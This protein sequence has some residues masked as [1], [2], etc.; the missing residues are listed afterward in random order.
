MKNRFYI[1]EN[2]KPYIENVSWPAGGG[3]LNIC[4][5]NADA[6][7]AF[8]EIGKRDAIAEY[9]LGKGFRNTIYE[10]D[11]EEWIKGNTKIVFESCIDNVW[12]YVHTEEY[13]ES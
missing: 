11:F 9:L 6:L 2:G 3:L 1:D 10:M 8:N 13:L 7:Y 4:D 12:G 5:Y